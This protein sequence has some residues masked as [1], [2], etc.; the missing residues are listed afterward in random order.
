MSTVE[1]MNLLRS[2]KHMTATAIMPTM[3]RSCL[4]VKPKNRCSLYFVGSCG[5]STFII[6]FSSCQPPS[7]LFVRSL[8]LDTIVTKHTS[9]IIGEIVDNSASTNV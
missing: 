9:E 3:L 8:S 1:S 6:S 5:I 4:V 7:A 2:A